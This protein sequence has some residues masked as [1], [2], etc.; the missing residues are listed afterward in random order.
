M[1]ESVNK[2]NDMNWQYT[3]IGDHGQRWGL[4]DT[5]CILIRKMELAFCNPIIKAEE[6]E[7]E[8]VLIDGTKVRISDD[9]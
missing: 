1:V 5:S 8:V 4:D 7:R 3:A 2:L 9:G 6:K